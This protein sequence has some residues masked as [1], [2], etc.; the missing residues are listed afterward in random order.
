MRSKIDRTGERNYNTFG[1]E[2][3]IIKYR[4]A[5]DIAVYF[6]QSDWIVKGVQ[7]DNFKKGN[8]K[9]QY[10]KRTFGIGYLGEGKYK[11]WENGKDTRV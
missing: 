11:A 3:M 9:C 5:K 6:P 2:M 7:Y 10:E 4:G 1:S 8:I